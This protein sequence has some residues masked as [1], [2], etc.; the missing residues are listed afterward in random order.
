MKCIGRL[1][2][3]P[4]ILLLISCGN[5]QTEIGGSG[6]IE[7]T[8][9]VFSAKTNGQL[10]SLN[11]DEG[12]QVALNDTIGLIDTS[13][14]VLQ[15]R[16]AEAIAEA[17]GLKLKIAAKDIKQA[18]QNLS[19][20]QTEFDRIASLLG[21]GS[22]N[23]QQ[24]DQ[25]QTALTQAR[26]TKEKADLGRQ[27]AQAEL[28]SAR[29]QAAIL[30]KQF[31]DSFP[32]IPMEGTIVTKYIEPGEL[33]TLGRPLVKI[34]SLDTVWVKIYLSPADLTRI[35]LGDQARIDP[36]NGDKNL[37][38]GTITW[39]SDQAEFTP[40]NVQSKEARADLVYA[41]KITIPNPG[42]I[43]KIG[44]PVSVKVR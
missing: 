15:L 12:D 42:H 32:L 2:I 22:A 40:K 17:A 37:L 44:M 30:K 10:I 16:Q 5:N 33:V 14:T 26:L 31:E 18:E 23:Q 25:A 6:L 27:A 20:A 13:T 43:L 35:N 29:S 7:A 38:P 8:D 9:V 36:E 39:I 24:Y 1:L 4:S 34:A 19:L 3:L 11:F 21:S 41:V 28:K